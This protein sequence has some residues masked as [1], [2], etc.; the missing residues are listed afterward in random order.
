MRGTIILFSTI[1]F[2]SLSCSKPTPLSSDLSLEIPTNEVA[3]S[4]LIYNPKNSLWTINEG[5]LFS[6]FA[7][8]YY[9]DGTLKEK[10][11]ILEGRKQ[12]EASKYYPDGH[13]K[14][15]SNYHKGKL[16]GEKKSWSPDS[17]HLLVSHLNYQSG[18]A[19]G[20]QK[21]WYSTGEIFKV[22][23]LN[24][25]KEEGIQQAFRK[26]GKLFA[27]YEAR[28]GRIFG[29]RKSALCFGLEEEEIQFN[30]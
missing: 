27:N 9:E 16:H 3:K 21:K 26:N 15:F 2:L 13:L 12:N 17:T 1:I 20:I 4:S 19:H 7:T 24:Q 22:L 25:G 18:K 10:F 23:N 11:G 28:N 6:G 29:L 14:S 5:E 8:T 30:D